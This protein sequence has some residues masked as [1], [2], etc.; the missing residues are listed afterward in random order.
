MKKKRI[1]LFLIV[2]LCSASGM[3]RGE[4]VVD[5]SKIPP[6]INKKDYIFYDM[7]YLEDD[8]LKEWIVGEDKDNQ[9]GMVLRTT[10]GGVH[11]QTKFSDEFVNCKCGVSAFYCVRFSDENIGYIGCDRGLILKTTNGGEKWFVSVGWGVVTDAE[12]RLVD[13]YIDEKYPFGLIL[14]AI[15]YD[16]SI[17][18]RSTDGG[19]EWRYHHL[20]PEHLQNEMITSKFRMWRIRQE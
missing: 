18:T 6:S 10:D 4:I 19:I 15:S 20:K 2:I 16:G 1:T 5:D 8:S 14:W 9:R 11:W 17:I 12:T 13:I 7:L 3:I